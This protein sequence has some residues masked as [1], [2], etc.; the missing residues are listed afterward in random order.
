MQVFANTEGKGWVFAMEH[1][2]ISG[3]GYHQRA[4]G[5][6]LAQLGCYNSMQ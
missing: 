2:D 5:E 3:L 4:L 6:K 1:L